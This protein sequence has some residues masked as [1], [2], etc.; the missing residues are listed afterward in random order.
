MAFS[1]SRFGQEEDNASLLVAAIGLETGELRSILDDV[2]GDSCALEDLEKKVEDG[3]GGKPG[4][5]GRD[6]WKK[7]YKITEEELAMSSLEDC[8]VTRMAVKDH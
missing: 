3:G 7:M 6:R 8:V 4:A 2:Q 1:H 5:V